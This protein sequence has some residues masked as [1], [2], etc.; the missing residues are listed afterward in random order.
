MD[1]RDYPARRPDLF[2][3]GRLVSAGAEAI[4]DAGRPRFVVCLQLTSRYTACMRRVIGIAVIVAAAAAAVRLLTGRDA[5]VAA[6]GNGHAADQERV[7]ILR[8]RIGAARRRL[9]DEF[10]SVRGSD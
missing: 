6:S 5:P 9:R 7:E 8:E 3:N 4:G 2:V 1:G 10:D